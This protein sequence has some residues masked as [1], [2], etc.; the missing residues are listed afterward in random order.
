MYTTLGSV[1]NEQTPKCSVKIYHG[2]MINLDSDFLF[3]T[4]WEPSQ[5]QFKCLKTC[6][7]SH[8]CTPLPILLDLN[9]EPNS[10]SLAT[11]VQWWKGSYLRW[12]Q[13]SRKKYQHTMGTAHSDMCACMCCWLACLLSFLCCTQKSIICLL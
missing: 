5:L 4:C 1:L 11:I 3:C 9:R 12:S 6:W 13:S 7:I 8:I 2:L 10:N